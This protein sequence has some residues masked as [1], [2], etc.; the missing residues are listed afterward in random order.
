MATASEMTSQE[1][2]LAAS[3]AAEVDRPPI[4]LWSHFPERDQTVA[5]LTASTLAWQERYAFDFVKF[6]PPGDYTTI[7]WG[8]ESVYEGAPGGTRSTTRFP[9]K[10]IED[11]GQLRPVDVRA[12]FNGIILEALRQ[13]R[14]ELDRDVPILQTIFTPLII[15]QK[16]SNDQAVAHLR[17]RPDLL[18]TSLD[19]IATTT[20]AMVEASF[21]AG[22]DGIFLAVRTADFGVTTEAEYHEFGLP[23]DLRVLAAV[24]DSAITILHFHG[25][26][27]M[28]HL[29]AEYPPGILNWHDRRTTTN[30]GEGQKTSGRPVAG[31]INERA[32]PTASPEEIAAEVRDAITQTGGRGVLITPGCVVPFAAPEANF[33]AATAAIVG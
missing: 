5:D 4:S 16:L 22:A 6:M 2:V 19:V 10:G 27:P 7:D 14:D 24:P 17:E 31:G 13:S 32:M 12:G 25:D 20:R 3:M 23:Y 28:L 1:R 26:Q 8:A 11:W 9:I 18:H 30:L 15:A 33:R 21:D 29:A